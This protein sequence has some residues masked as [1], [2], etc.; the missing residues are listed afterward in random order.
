MGCNKLIV[1]NGTIADLYIKTE[2][3]LPDID[4]N[5]IIDEINDTNI[6]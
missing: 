3:C 4:A 6:L 1:N 5:N 2:N